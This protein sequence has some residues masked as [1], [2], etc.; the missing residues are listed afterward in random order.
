MSIVPALA[1]AAVC[2]P[3]VACAQGDGVDAAGVDPYT[4]AEPAAMARAGVAA[5]Q[6]FEWAEGHT[7]VGIQSLM[8][9]EPFRFVETAHFKIASS[10][11]TMAIPRDAAGRRA[12]RAELVALRAKLPGIDVDAR[13]LDPWLR[14][15]LYAH[16]L[17]R[18]YAE[19]AAR[20]GVSEAAMARCAP[21]GAFAV[22]YAG[23]GPHLGQRGKFLVVLARSGA[24]LGS[25][26]RNFLDLP[27]PRTTARHHLARSGSLLLLTAEQLPEEDLRRD[28]DL[29]A[30]VAYHAAHLFVDA[31]RSYWHDCPVWFEEG[32]AHW[33]RAQA[34]P[35]RA[36]FSARP[37][38][39]PRDPGA[40]DWATN[41]RAR[42][43]H[44]SSVPAEE[45]F[46]L[47]NEALRFEDHLAAWSR[48]DFLLTAHPDAFPLFARGLKG[49][50]ASATPPTPNA[51]EI[52]A[53]QTRALAQV[54]GWSPADFDARWSE[55]ALRTYP[56]TKT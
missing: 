11:P 32:V 45:L 34:A 49:P 51:A 7:T 38:L 41:V 54:F 17:E 53:R 10:L 50:D 35:T 22:D 1:L 52:D 24:S 33:F 4:K 47:R 40:A 36:V 5:L 23:E 16:R 19:F 27:A 3:V 39:L 2:F 26:A 12:L 28:E 56:K 21:G 6:R 48:V 30:A 46:R 31:Y 18:A 55:W 14:T 43:A 44:G 15:H 13:T 25:Y 8:G 42:L 20:F 29:H 9:F 37:R